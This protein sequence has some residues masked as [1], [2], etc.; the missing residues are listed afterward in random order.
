MSGYLSSSFDQENFAFYGK[1]MRGQQE[2]KPRWK[3]V[4]QVVDGSV[5][6]QLGK[7]YTDKYFTADAKKRMLELVD[8]LQSAYEARINN[9]DWMSDST[10]AKAKD[11]LHAFIKK[12][13]YPD[14][15]RDYSRAR[16]FERFL[17]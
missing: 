12:I 13:G 2:Q 3:R 9:L 16:N 14:K 8:N 7:M 5:G 17:C 1:V 11:K 15:W 4:L 6:E 10:K